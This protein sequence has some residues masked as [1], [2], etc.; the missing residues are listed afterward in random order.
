MAGWLPPATAHRMSAPRRYGA[1]CACLPSDETSWHVARKQASGQ[2]RWPKC[3]RVHYD[4]GT[5]SG[6]RSADP[7]NTAKHQLQYLPYH[8]SG[9]RRYFDSYIE[10]VLVLGQLQLPFVCRPCRIHYPS[11]KT[12]KPKINVVIDTLS[13]QEHRQYHELYRILIHYGS[14]PWPR[15]T[16]PVAVASNGAFTASES[17]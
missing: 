11:I 13:F 6:V 14:P 9:P 7:A 17:R 12:S 8:R 3:P 5:I 4:N 10:S 2:A 1:C 15:A 16:R